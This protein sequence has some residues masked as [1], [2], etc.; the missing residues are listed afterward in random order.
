MNWHTVSERIG[1]EFDFN[2]VGGGSEEI[3]I[4]RAAGRLI[5]RIEIIG[6]RR[7]K[8]EQILKWIST[9]PGDIC[10]IL[11]LQSD[12]NAILKTGYFDKQRTRVFAEEGERG[13]L[14]IVFEAFELP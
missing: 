2:Y 12:L 9:R 7:L 8:H 3:S 5:D 13:E 6:Y 4:D 11:Q 14:G 1:F 10:N